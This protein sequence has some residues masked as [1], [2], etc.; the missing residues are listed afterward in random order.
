M[1]AEQGI[2]AA[3]PAEFLVRPDGTVLGDDGTCGT[4]AAALPYTGGW[5]GGWGS[6]SRSATC[7]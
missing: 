3:D 5:R 1:S 6:W 4:L 7:G 2:E